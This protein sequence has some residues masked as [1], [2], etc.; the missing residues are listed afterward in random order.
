MSRSYM[1]VVPKK[2]WV[3]SVESLMLL[4]S[5]NANT[6]SN[7]VTEDDGSAPGGVGI[8]R[9]FALGG[10]HTASD[11]IIHDWLT[12][13]GQYD[14]KTVD[15]HLSALRYCEKV[16]SGKSFSKITREDV[17]KV[18]D[19]LKR[20]ALS[21][22]MDSLSS[23]SIKHVVS[24]LSAFLDWLLKQ[25]GFKSLPRTCRV[26]LGCPRRFW[27][28]RL[29]CR[30]RTTLPSKRRKVCWPRCLQSPCSINVL[31]RFLRSLSWAHC[32]QTR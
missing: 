24:H 30:R 27:R 12:Y 19:D 16:L 28:R 32:G 25:N 21:D 23:S 9:A 15:R 1:K 13:S 3:Y 14:V 4:Y 8:T 31:G 18:R 20:R 2:Y 10:L 26:T 22:E 11:R 5:V 17:A 29:R 7:W 6:I